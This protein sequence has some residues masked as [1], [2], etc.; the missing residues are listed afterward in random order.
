MNKIENYRELMEYIIKD[1]HGISQQEIAYRI[2]IAPKTMYTI[3]N[4]VEP[5]KKVR[6]LLNGFAE[7]TYG[8]TVDEL[9][10]G[11]IQIIKKQVFNISGDFLGGNL[12]E[13]FSVEKKEKNDSLEISKLRDYLLRK[14]MSLEEENA[15][16]RA[17]IN[18][19]KK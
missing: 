8:V 2:G 7:K 10:G 3:L 19:L 16:L 4:G 1:L 15:K 18:F 11:R 13:D 5:G 6:R 17:E 12:S 14:V 9:E